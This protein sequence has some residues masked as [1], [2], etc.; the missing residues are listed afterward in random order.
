MKKIDYEH[1]ARFLCPHT[2]T[3]RGDDLYF[4]VKRADLGENTYKSDLYVLRDGTPRRLTSGGDVNAYWLLSGGAVFPALR[5]K[6]DRESAERGVPL[7]VLQRLPYDGGEAAEWL[8]LPYN[9]GEFR[10]VSEER[11]FFSAEYRP[12][13]DAALAEAG[14]D[15]EKAAAKLK[16][17]SDYRVLDELPFWWNGRGFT[18]GRRERL[19]LWDRGTVTPVTGPD[20]NASLSALSADGKRLFFSRASAQGCHPLYD[21]MAELDTET[22]ACTDIS[23]SDTAQHFGA[24]PLPDGRVLILA[25][26]GAEHGLNENPRLFLREAGETRLLYGEGVHNFYNSVNSDVKADRAVG[27]ESL[28]RDGGAFFLDTQDDRTALVRVDLADGAVT[29][30]TRAAGNITDAVLW[31]GGFALIAMRGGEGS[32]LWALSPDGRETR[33]TALNAALFAEYEYSEPVPLSFV[34]EK[35]DEIRG[36]V[37]PPADREPGKKYPAILDVHGGPKTAYGSCLFHEMQLWASRGWAVLFCNPTG[38]DGRGDVFADIRG[39]YGQQDFRDLMAF[40]DEALRRFDFLDPDRLGVTGGSYG[41]FMTNWIIGHTRRFRAAASQRSIADWISFF[42]NSDIGSSFVLDQT[43]GDPWSDP[44]KCRSQSPL[45]F[46]PQAVTPTLF[47]HS[48]EDYR[49]PLSQGMEMYSAL[50]S[51]GVPARMC[52]FRGENHEL[53]RSG[54]PLHRVRRLREITEWF[55]KYL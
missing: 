6:K 52:V 20:E 13:W 9:A 21:R 24:C 44:E 31:R 55:E 27:G 49:C 46:A 38:S 36:W 19:Y 47:I 23:V 41:G 53:S 40:T 12:A 7:T 2:L 39:Q 4:C 28:C 35:G 54:K 26:V 15:A 50:L 11:F 17:D 3:A 32:E 45:T 22:L 16:E 5:E 8:R 25:S 18:N 14:G 10:F 30:V 48:D 51:R 33:L 37:I 43:G 1:F 34:N 42:G 29:T